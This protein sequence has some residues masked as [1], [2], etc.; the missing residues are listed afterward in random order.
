MSDIR[1]CQQQGFMYLG[2]WWAK[3]EGSGIDIVSV[4]VGGRS[5]QV[6][7]NDKT[8]ALASSCFREPFRTPLRFHLRAQYQ[9]VLPVNN[10]LCQAGKPRKAEKTVAVYCEEL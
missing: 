6:T 8:E 1:R 2:V 5:P 9:P 7:L 3:V 10:C 4:A